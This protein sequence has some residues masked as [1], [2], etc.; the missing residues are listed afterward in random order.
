MPIAIKDANTTVVAISTQSDVAGALVPMHIPASLIGGIATPVSPTAPLPVVQGAGSAA[1]DGSGVIIAGSVAQ[2][3]FGSVLPLHGYVIA[4]NSGGI[5][6]A[7]DVGT[8]QAG[9]ASIPINPGDVFM[10]PPGYRPP[11]AVSLFGNTTG[12]AFAARSY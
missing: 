5:L 4:N 2:Y 12:Q 3:L 10:T 1:I 6:W 7:C 11:L 9:G 8:A